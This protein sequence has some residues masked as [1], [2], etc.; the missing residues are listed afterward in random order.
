MELEIVTRDRWG[1]RQPKSTQFMATPVP[2]LFIHHT[3]MNECND[4]ESCKRMM[5]SMQNFHMD[6]RGW[7][8]IGYNFVIGGDGR[9]YEGR[10]WN[11]VGAH[12]KGYNKVG[13]AFTLMGNYTSKA[14]SELMISTTNKLITLAENQ[15]YVKSDYQLH[16]HRDACTTECPGDTLYS[17]IEKW[18]HFKKGPLPK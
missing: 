12:T 7:A 2:H 18:P 1:A 17:I 3:A 9:V 16:G 14:P 13:I 15:N 8:D 5:Q 6:E 4:F 11:R 10:G